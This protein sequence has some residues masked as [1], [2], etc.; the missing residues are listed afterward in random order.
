L[1]A[2]ILVALLAGIG[3]GWL[4]PRSEPASVGDHRAYPADSGEITLAEG[5]RR[6]GIAVPGCVADEDL[7][8]AWINEGFSYYQDAYLTFRASEECMN[9]FLSANRMVARVTQAAQL[10][11]PEAET[12]PFKHDLTRSAE[13]VAELGWE[14]GP[15]ERFEQFGVTTASS[16]SMTAFV[17]R[18]PDS[19]NLRAYVCAYRAG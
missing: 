17:R 2:A 19:S 10:A 14:V 13:V 11:G 18:L 4:L 7:R 16:Y 9:T 8:Y 1:V 3:V 6:F 15:D 12:R 5:L